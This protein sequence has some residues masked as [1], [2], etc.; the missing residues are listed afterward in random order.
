MKRIILLSATLLIIEGQVLAQS[1]KEKI[2]I[3]T[4]SKKT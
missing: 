2:E 1:E 4:R 3:E